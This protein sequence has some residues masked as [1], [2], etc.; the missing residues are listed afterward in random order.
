[1]RCFRK[2]CVGAR[3]GVCVCVENVEEEPEDKYSH[4]LSDFYRLTYCIPIFF[5]TK[6]I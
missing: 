2:M 6:L 5:D 1:M 4:L 3:A